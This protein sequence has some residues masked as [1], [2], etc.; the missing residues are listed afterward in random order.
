MQKQKKCKSK[1]KKKDHHR[2]YTL[3]I[4]YIITS[5]FS[6][7]WSTKYTQLQYSMST[8]FL[9]VY[10]TNYVHLDF[11]TTVPLASD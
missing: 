7:Y 3:H 1:S 6:Y 4:I 5:R 9:H 8:V 10:T 11:L 2:M